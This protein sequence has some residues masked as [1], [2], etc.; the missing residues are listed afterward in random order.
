V[1]NLVKQ[2]EWF[3]KCGLHFLTLAR[4]LR[5]RNY[6]SNFVG[7]RA[8]LGDNELFGFR[9]AVDFFKELEHLVR[10]NVAPVRCGLRVD[11][12]FLVVGVSNLLCAELGFPE[13]QISGCPSRDTQRQNV[14]PEKVRTRGTERDAN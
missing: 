11:D 14:A 1:L 9:K 7:E 2:I 6:L 8:R 5:L 4:P 12:C 10:H 13:G 3:R